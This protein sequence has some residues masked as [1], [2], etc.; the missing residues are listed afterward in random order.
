MPIRCVGDTNKIISNSIEARNAGKGFR[1]ME[2]PRPGDDRL[3]NHSV[4]GV[5]IRK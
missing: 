1:E 5:G 2:W 3:I 4:Y